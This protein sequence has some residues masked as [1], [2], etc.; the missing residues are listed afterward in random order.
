MNG[1]RLIRWIVR[2]IPAVVLVLTGVF[3]IL[4]GIVL[5]F[6]STVNN[7][8]DGHGIP[9]GNLAFGAAL[10]LCGVAL[11]WVAWGVWRAR[12][13]PT[14][15][16][17]IFSVAVIAYLAWVAPGTL[18]PHDFRPDPITGHLVPQY[19]TRAQLFIIAIIPAYAIVFACLIVAE[20]RER[21][22]AQQ[23]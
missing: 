9:P 22:L 11:I 14:H 15:I 3:L 1:D 4:V 6:G 8:P 13:W 18:N 5:P 10:I 7:G 12:L 16:A 23:H 17:L 19:D 2:G 21:R 20:L